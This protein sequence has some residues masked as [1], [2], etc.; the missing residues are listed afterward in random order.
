MMTSSLS[1]SV[2]ALLLLSLAAHAQEKPSQLLLNV[3][4]TSSGPFGGQKGATC[5]KLY[6]D[7]RLIYSHRSTSAMGVQDEKGKVSHPE[8]RDSREYRFPERD[9][10]ELGDFSDFLQS[11]AV[12]R[13]KTYFP[14]P[15]SAIDFLETS[16]VQIFFPNGKSQQ[17]QAKEYYVASLV[18]KTKYPSALILLMDKIE[19]FEDTVAEKGVESDVSASCTP[20]Y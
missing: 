10:W 2:I 18:E 13:L 20:K 15:H 12:R 19:R 11:K 17:L 6:S 4:E 7:G 16:T 9:L 1:Y 5:L 8:R 3:E 14:P